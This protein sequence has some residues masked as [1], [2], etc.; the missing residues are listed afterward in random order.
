MSRRLLIVLAALVPFFGLAA[1]AFAAPA[2]PM[3]FC[4]EFT[5]DDQEAMAGFAGKTCLVRDEAKLKV[6]VKG[7]CRWFYGFYWGRP[8]LKC[9]SVDGKYTITSPAGVRAEAS[10]TGRESNEAQVDAMGEAFA[11]VAGKYKLDVF[12]KVEMMGFSGKWSRAVSK[13]RQLEIDATC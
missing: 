9:K 3:E 6:V 5:D 4:S 13:Q 2:D 12:Y 8:P 1:P 11:C 7:N 10:M